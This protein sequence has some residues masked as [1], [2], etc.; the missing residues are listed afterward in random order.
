LFTINQGYF[1]Q[2]G[3]FG[4]PLILTV[5]L[6]SFQLEGT[7]VNTQQWAQPITAGVNGISS[8]K[9]RLEVME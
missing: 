3:N 8:R 9:C 6:Q 5:T 2:L 7:L 4:H 1:G